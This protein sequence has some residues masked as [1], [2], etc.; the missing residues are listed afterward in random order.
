M[1]KLLIVTLFAIS[2]IGAQ[3]QVRMPAPSPLQTIKQD[4]ATGN[5]E[6]VYSRPSAKERK[7]FGDLVP[8]G[9]LWRTGANAATVIKFSEPVEIDGK[10][11]DSGSYALYTIPGAE[12]WEVIFNKGVKNSG[13]NGYKETEDVLRFKTP[14]TRIKNEVENFTMLFDNI[15]PESMELQ[16]MWEKTGIVVP[17]KANIKDNLRRQIETALRGDKKPYWQAAQFYN[18]YDKNYVKALENV[19][20]ATEENP[21][22]FWIFHYKAKI[23]KDMGDKAG[24][25]ASAQTSLDLARAENNADYVKLNE[26]LMKKL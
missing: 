25:R 8:Y 20:K 3:S 11:L 18:E 15:R 7:V 12:Y 10:K 26:D 4:F 6:L 9:K 13:V 24:A 5:V 14:T 23:Q 2:S 22:A 17:I 1:K 19:N 21:K 16:L